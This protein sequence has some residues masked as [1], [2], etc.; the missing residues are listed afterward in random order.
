MAQAP[1]PPPTDD[2]AFDKMFAGSLASMKKE[3]TLATMSAPELKVAVERL[4]EQSGLDPHE[5]AGILSEVTDQLVRHA[6]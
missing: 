2:T 5:A 1:S 4:V 3:N 6:K